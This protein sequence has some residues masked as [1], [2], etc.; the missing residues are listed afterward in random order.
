M[1][2]EHGCSR[3]GS[4]GALVELFGEGDQL[5]DVLRREQGFYLADVGNTIWQVDFDGLD[6]L[7]PPRFIR[8]SAAGLFGR[9]KAYPDMAGVSA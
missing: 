2:G 9:R 4:G 8:A 3:E 5:V 7:A 1:G 6:A